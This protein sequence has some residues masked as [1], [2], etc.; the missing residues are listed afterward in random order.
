MCSA[1]SE[2][3]AS[4]SASP[5]KS[6]AKRPCL[7]VWPLRLAGFPFNP[8][9]P[10][11]FTWS[12]PSMLPQVIVISFLPDWLFPEEIYKDSLNDDK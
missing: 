2:K 5:D 8:Y 12:L 11:Q 6:Q 7:L 3:L 9:Q 4:P 10:D 1:T